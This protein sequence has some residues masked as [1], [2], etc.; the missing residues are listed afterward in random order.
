MRTEISHTELCW[1]VP[2]TDTVYREIAALHTSEFIAVDNIQW[3]KISCVP[4]WGISSLK[5]VFCHSM[6]WAFQ[7]GST[8]RQMSPMYMYGYI[9]KNLFK[10]YDINIATAKD[11]PKAY[12]QGSTA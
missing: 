8:E 6:I 5:S 9:G 12:S 4:A 7:R 2:E 3:P 10:A 1:Q 11:H